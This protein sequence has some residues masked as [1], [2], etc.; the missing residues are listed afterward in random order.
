MPSL[1]NGGQPLKGTAG[2]STIFITLPGAQLALGKTPT[3]STGYTL[4]T[5]P[6]GQLGFTTTIGGVTFANSIMQTQTPN[7][8]LSIQSNGT[9]TLNLNGNILINGNSLTFNTGTIIDLTVTNTAKFLNTLTTVLIDGGLLVSKDVQ[10]G[11]SLN[12]FGAVFIAPTDSSVT[13]TP[14]G[15]GSVDI[16]PTTLGAIDNM[17]I[18][19]RVAASATFT[20]L[21]AGIVSAT[22][23]F[24]NGQPVGGGSAEISDTPPL[25]PYVGKFWWDSTVGILRVYY[26]DGTH[27]MWVDASPSIQGDTGPVGPQGP[28][29]VSGAISTTTNNLL[30]ITDVTVSTSTNTGALTV[31]GGVGIGGS[32]YANQIFSN[33]LAVLT[34]ATV[35]SLGVS[36]LIVDPAGLFASGST[37]SVTLRNIDTLDSVVV[38]G[39][40]SSHSIS[41][42]S[43]TAS[44]SSISG[45]LTVAG[46]V[47]IAG[48]LFVG[49]SINVMAADGTHGSIT[50]TSPSNTFVVNGSIVPAPTNSRGLG[51]ATDQWNSLYAVEIFENQNRVITS[52]AP[53]SGTGIGVTYISTTGPYVSYV[54]TNLGVQAI[55]AGPG[56]IVNANTGTVT[57]SNNSSFQNVTDVGTTTTN[58]I[59]IT[60]TSSTALV[61]AGTI[62]AAAIF[63]NNAA[64]WTTA[65]LTD[66]GQLTNIV[67]YIP[68]SQLGLYGV[69]RV[70][71]GYGIAVN[72]STGNVTVTN[73]G[74][75]TLTAGAGIS[76]NTASGAVLVTNTGV[77]SLTLGTSTDITLSTTSGGIT[78]TSNSTLQTVTDRG[79]STTNAIAITNPTISTSFSNGALI[80]TGGVGIGGNLHVLGAVFSSSLFDSNNRVLTSVTPVA[81][82]G[83]NLTNLVVSGSS[84]TFTI[85]NSGVLSLSGTQFLG[86]STATGNIILTNLGVQSLVSTAE[87]TVSASTGSNISIGIAST[88][89]SVTSRGSGTNQVITL[90]NVTDSVSTT[91]GALVVNGGVGIG[92]KLTVGGQLNVQN[93]LIISN[94]PIIYNQP[95]AIVDTTLTILD[96][97]STSLY[98]SAKYLI[99][100]SN[101]GSNQYQTTEILLIQDGT[102]ASIE[103]T[104]VFSGADNLMLFT[105]I[106]TV[107]TVLLR[108]IGSLAGNIVK[109][110]PTYITI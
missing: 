6:N 34:S 16:N 44:T 101:A 14:K 71:P 30:H 50:Y 43:S 12:A 70:L 59:N 23:I 106:V 67:G 26:N 38:R 61:V 107:G 36:Q 15:I 51:A 81:G 108:G 11:G 19:T 60:N 69:T 76:L 110:Q 39:S 21:T 28:Q 58:A 74:V 88:L 65:T 42:T 63:S 46:G 80:V 68:A 18:G 53:T 8:N 41:I 35:A 20:T 92:G 45:A 82:T 100:V 27:N 90:S 104:S 93:D 75:V 99:S 102:N 91:S 87:V 72:V 31:A 109:V 48:D 54:I 13:I 105:A 84:S 17:S 78:L 86:V 77:T 29:G 89:Q 56:T 103:Q 96:S 33:G 97:F 2:T 64:V 49:N 1:L 4:V 32:L 10:V 94:H 66:V 95:A 85:N 57:I 83:I 55:Y 7:G 5:G 52:V 25:L 98:R 73:I 3:T 40:T 47:G 37:G 62:R 24:V 22:G 79:A 9:G